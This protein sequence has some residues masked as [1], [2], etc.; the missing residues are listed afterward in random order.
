MQAGW[1]LAARA[2]LRLAELRPA[3]A[4]GDL[5]AAGDL[6]ARLRILTA[7]GASWRS[8]A[9]LAHLA[10]GKRAETRALAAEEVALPQAF[11]GPRTIGIALRAAGLADGGRRRLQ[12]LPQPVR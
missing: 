10:L 8:D 4:L 1:L 7:A 5:L 12:L 3:A 11:G 9:A 2:R 6:F